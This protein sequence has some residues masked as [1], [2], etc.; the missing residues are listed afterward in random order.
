MVKAGMSPEQTLRAAT[1]TSASLLGWD[2]KVGTVAPGAYADVVA[3]KDDPRK[4]IGAVE[5]PS[6]VIK[7]GSVVHDNRR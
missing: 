3:M 2:G 5:R 6:V 4:D 7:G 1:A